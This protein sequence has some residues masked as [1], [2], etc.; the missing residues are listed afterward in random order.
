MHEI[1]LG[2]CTFKPEL[3]LP[4]TLDGSRSIFS[5]FY[6]E[7]K[8][9]YFSSN[10]LDGRTR[11]VAASVIADS[12]YVIFGSHGSSYSDYYLTYDLKNADAIIFSS[13]NMNVSNYVMNKYKDK[14]LYFDPTFVE[15]IR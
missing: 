13:K 15:I 10:T 1:S 6:N 11:A 3:R 2:I 14:T 7:N 4:Y 5:L 12:D 9:S 8:I